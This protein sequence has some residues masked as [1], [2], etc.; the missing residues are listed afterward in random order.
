MFSNR[1]VWHFL[2][3]HNLFHALKESGQNIGPSMID[4]FVAVNV[5]LVLDFNFK[6]TCVQI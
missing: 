3:K 1:L 4:A 6:K 5:S 2:V